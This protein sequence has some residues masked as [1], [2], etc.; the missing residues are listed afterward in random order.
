[1]A[2]IAGARADHKRAADWDADSQLNGK[3][4][5]AGV[6]LRYKSFSRQRRPQDPDSAIA[7]DQIAATAPADRASASRFTATPSSTLP[8][9][10]RCPGRRHSPDEPTL[11]RDDGAELVQR[12]RQRR[13]RD[14]HDHAG[15]YFVGI[16]L[17]L[18]ALELLTTD[19]NVRDSLRELHTTVAKFRDEL[20]AICAGER[21]GVP[22]G[23]LL[24]A[25]LADLIPKWEQEVGIA[26]RF[27]G[28]IKDL[29]E[30]DDATAE[31]IFRVVQEALTNVAKHA[32]YAS[33]VS[34]SLRLKQQLKQRILS[35]EIEDDGIAK[36]GL[37]KDRRWNGEHHGGL[38]GMRERVAELG[39]HFDVCHQ[40]GQGT[41][42]VAMIPIDRFAKKS[43]R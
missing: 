4:R 36:P 22:S 13:A 11:F 10:E 19:R 42:L 40:D 34:V 26:A 24:M 18:A 5:S 23:N 6:K 8:R 3:K 15:Q 39:G 33:Q 25:A 28:E 29:G 12:E 32:S 7:L 38:V 2:W 31:A 35:L 30:L 27:D 43:T 14:V 41:R 9:S 17:R 21:C 37:R 20:R 16:M 1:M